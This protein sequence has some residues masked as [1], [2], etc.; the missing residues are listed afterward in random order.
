MIAAQYPKL[1][2]PQEIKPAVAN[3]NEVEAGIDKSQGGAGSAHGT[4]VRILLGAL[5]N[6][7]M[8]IFYRSEKPFLRIGTSGCGVSFNDCVDREAA[9]DLATCVPAHAVGD[10]GD[11]A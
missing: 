4:Q 8:R 3:M 7:A 11:P 9:G 6:T 2:F 10:N 1:P 5:L